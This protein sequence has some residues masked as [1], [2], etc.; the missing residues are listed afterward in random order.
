PREC[1]A[2]PPRTAARAGAGGGGGEVRQAGGSRHQPPDGRIEE[3]LGVLHLD[4]AAGQNAREQFRHAVALHHGERARGAALVEP[5]APDAPAHRALDAEKG[6]G[7]VMEVHQPLRYLIPVQPRWNF[8]SWRCSARI[9]RT[10]PVTERI[11]TVSVSI[12]SLRK[13]TPLSRSPLVTPVAANR[14]SPL[15]MSSIWYFLR[16]SLIPIFL[17]RSR[18]SSVS[19]TRRHC[20]WPPMQRSAAAASTPSGAPP[21]PM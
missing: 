5:L 16:G 17:A 7:T 20:I 18:F 13:R 1:R 19:S 6:T 12:T 21:M 3:G 11:T 15:T 4:A 8:S 14:Q 10:V 9:Q 2:R